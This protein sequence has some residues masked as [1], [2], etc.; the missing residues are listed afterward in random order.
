MMNKAQLNHLPFVSRSLLSLLTLSII[1]SY[2]GVQSCK[3][4]GLMWVPS[5]WWPLCF[6]VGLPG[7]SA[8]RLVPVLLC[9]CSYY[10]LAECSCVATTSKKSLSILHVTYLSMKWTQIFNQAPYVTSW[11]HFP[12]TSPRPQW[13]AFSPA[14]QLNVSLFHRDRE[15]Q[16]CD[17][18]SSASTR[19]R[20]PAPGLLL[21]MLICAGSGDRLRWARRKVTQHRREW[22]LCQNPG[23]GVRSLV[24]GLR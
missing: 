12:P 22:R 20:K 9:C 16:V 24:T 4:A 18:V 21:I 6:L 2:Y 11:L 14:S 15:P 5:H 8:A 1:D 10:I 17:V 3:R 13:T 23:G 19:G 7:D